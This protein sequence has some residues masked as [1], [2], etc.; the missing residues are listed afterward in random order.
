MKYAFIQDN[1]MHYTVLHLCEVLDVPPGNYTAW[2]KRPVCQRVQ[3]NAHLDVHIQAVFA[4]HKG[5][6]VVVK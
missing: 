3:G 1:Q 6:S 4:E 2:R 5:R